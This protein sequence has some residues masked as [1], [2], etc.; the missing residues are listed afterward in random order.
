[1][2]TS[3][4]PAPLEE[5]ASASSVRYGESEQLKDKNEVVG[6]GAGGFGDKVDA[7]FFFSSFSFQRLAA[8][9]AFIL[10]RAASERQG[11]TSMRSLCQQM[12]QMSRLWWI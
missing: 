4:T 10:L 8:E 1:M 6:R 11:H 2:F 5:E 12:A 9:A 7:T 3:T